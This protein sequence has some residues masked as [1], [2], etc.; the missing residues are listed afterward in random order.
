MKILIVEV[1]YTEYFCTLIHIIIS[2]ASLSLNKQLE[3][4]KEKINRYWKVHDRSTTK[5]FK[6]GGISSY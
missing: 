3:G 1:N 6:N 4:R 2:I 5:E